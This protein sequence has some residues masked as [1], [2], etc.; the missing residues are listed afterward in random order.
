MSNT[1]NNAIQGLSFPTGIR[2][3]SPSSLK[4]T[5]TVIKLR[6]PHRKHPACPIMRRR[7]TIGLSKIYTMYTFVIFQPRQTLR[8]RMWDG[9]GVQHEWNIRIHKT[10]WKPWRKTPLGRPGDKCEDI[11]EKMGRW[12]VGYIRLGL[13]IRWYTALENAIMNIT[14]PQKAGPKTS[15]VTI[16]FSRTTL[17]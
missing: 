1:E 13:D 11:I 8:I 15:C 5:Q 17:L 7:K 10:G 2:P 14:V 9:W 6:L 4:F 16:S 12:S 3:L